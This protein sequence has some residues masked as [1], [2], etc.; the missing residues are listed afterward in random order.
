MKI[1][2]VVGTSKIF[3]PAFGLVFLEWVTHLLSDRFRATTLKVK[4][5]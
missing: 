4:G 3:D 2:E 5:E 1:P